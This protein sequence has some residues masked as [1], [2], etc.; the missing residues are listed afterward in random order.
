[1][2]K[3]YS[4]LLL[5]LIALISSSFIFAQTNRVKITVIWPETAYENKVEVYN[6]FSST[7]PVLTICNTNGPDDCYSETG[8]E[9]FTATYDLGC[10]DET[11][12]AIAESYSIKLFSVDD[13][14]WGGTNSSV[15][16]NVGSTDIDPG[17]DVITN[18]GGDASIDGYTIPF[19]VSGNQCTLED[20]D[21]DFISDNIDQDDDNDGILDTVEGLGTDQVSCQ[22][23]ALVFLSGTDGSSDQALDP[24]STGAAGEVGAVYRFANASEGY[25]VLVEIIEINNASLEDLDNDDPDD[26]GNIDTSLETTINFES[27][28]DSGITFRFTLVD[29]GESVA[30]QTLFSIGG[31]T[32]DCDGTTTFQESVRYF[33][34]SAYGVDNPTSLTQDIYGDGAG[35]TAGEV[36]YGGFATNAILRSY[37]Q[38]KLDAT[39]GI[40]D[41]DYFDIRMQLEKDS[42]DIDVQRLYSMSFTQCDI[43][44]YKAPIITILTGADT[45]G[46]GNNDQ[47]DID[48]D[49]DGIPD[50][51]E[52]QPTIGYIEPSGTFDYNP[53]IGAPT[54]IDAAYGSGL[55]PLDTDADGIFD[56][57]DSDSDNDGTPDIDENGI[58]YSASNLGTDTDGDGLDDEFEGLETNDPLDVNDEIEDPEFD[59]P[60][61]DED[62]RD[63]GGDV[64][65]RDATTFG[66]A[67]IDFD[68][69]DDYLDS[70]QILDGKSSATI[71]AWIKLN[72]SFNANGF[73]IGQESFNLF[74]DNAGSL[75]VRVNGT[76]SDLISPLTF[77]LNKW[78][79]V[80]ATY[81]ETL[82][83]VLYVNG[84]RV[85][86]GT[87]EGVLTANGDKFTIG[88]N[89]SSTDSEFFKGSIDE[90]RVFNTALTDGELRQMVFQEIEENTSGNF[91]KGAVVP[92][93]IKDFDPSS[94][95]L[96]WASLEAYYTMNIITGGK[97]F[98]ESGYADRDATLYNINS[99]QE[100]TSPIPYETKQ[101][102]DWG[103]TVTWLNGNVWDIQDLAT[104][105]DWAIFRIN[106]GNEVYHDDSIKSYGLLIDGNAKL[107]V[108][109][110]GQLEQDYELQNGWYLELNGTIDLQDDSQLVQTENSE[111]VTGAFG[112]LLRRQEG[113]LNYFWYNYW[114]SPVG[115]QAATINSNTDFNIG[116]I[117]DNDGIDGFTFTDEHDAEDMISRRWLYKFQ[118]GLTYYDWEQITETESSP[119]EPGLGYTQKGIN[120]STDPNDEQEYTFV[121]KPN[122]GVILITANDVSDSFEATNGGESVQDVTLTTTLVGNPY[123]SVLDGPEFIRDNEG[124]IGG[125]IY[126]WE[127][128]AGI[129]HY[130]AEYEGGYGTINETATA[131]AYQWNDPDL[132][133]S[134]L[135]KT[136][137]QYIPVAQGFFVEVI[138]DLGNIEF[139]NSQRIFKKE[140]DPDGPIFFRSSNSENQSSTS[141]NNSMGII[142]LEL[143][144]SNGNKRNFVL[145]FGER[146]TDGYDYGFDSR[147]I[148]PQDDDLNSYLNDE[149]M[150]IQ[151]YSPITDDKVID[152]VF[153][154]TGTYNY[155]IEI[156]EIKYISEDQNIF[157]KDN[158]T[159]TDFD[160]RTGTYNFTSDFSGEDTDR[161]DVVFKATTLDIDN[162]STDNT[163]IFVNNYEHKLYV[164]GL[165]T[166]AKQLN[167]TNMLG[168]NIR[169]LNNVSSQTLDN[170][171]DI[172]NL[173]SGIYII[174]VS[175]DDNQTI[176][177]KVIIE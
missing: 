110:E 35:I 29:T 65:Y 62:V 117:K 60:D 174:S 6:Q 88:S 24:S 100:Q 148:D 54:G 84:E 4:K 143:T 157:I 123:P 9:V 8:S 173:S 156:I 170:G 136:P 80:A 28:S 30:T 127:Q 167:I 120:S 36:T 90:V 98:D 130:L 176:N 135:V 11:N 102:G 177:K 106:E 45:D 144:V 119:I 69:V 14:S 140:T 32:W 56:F 138:T 16:V 155:T 43:F 82:G 77:D 86:S 141:E 21:G 114:S 33:N 72:D 104:V 23:P 109:L 39:D 169:S 83:L 115:I 103:N 50:N 139:N 46:D 10:L 111:L 20:T 131:P 87:G 74:V 70:A 122:N 101:D 175:N 99:I 79:H 121:G 64:D 49:N 76:T 154:S 59:L 133:V 105:K 152:L 151:S 85:D 1:M 142:R 44:D 89:Q 58:S 128:W 132:D 94:V 137:S 12:S 172:S 126:L 147:T 31:T 71:M 134:D 163:L 38:F 113:N 164:K 48:S 7:I 146:T 93:D 61:T 55:D 2:K 160:L 145:G 118:N 68:G 22:V 53:E 149:K 41:N 15:V 108:G 5:L 75:N 112:K 165:T 42:D 13:N 150:V 66:S 124:V 19:V 129:G 73:V 57:L 17:T 162:F 171:L 37:F 52:A 95:A 158:L 78:V 91:V 67:T 40:T 47:L 159:N 161:F 25:D 51:V 116:M 168:L 18:D 125:T 63:F 97:T 3:N 96:P 27:G 107:T 92:L 81:D 26:G 34:P 166:Q 153:N